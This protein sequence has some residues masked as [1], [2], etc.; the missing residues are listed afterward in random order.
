MKRWFKLYQTKKIGSK[1]TESRSAWIAATSHK[2][3]IDLYIVRE[4]LRS[5]II[6]A[7]DAVTMICDDANEQQEF[8]LK[9]EIILIDPEEAAR[10]RLKGVKTEHGT[11][12][13]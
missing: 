10:R 3:A 1:N 8:I 4:D 5:D 13:L 9:A 12:D 2:E 6:N 11:P 7:D